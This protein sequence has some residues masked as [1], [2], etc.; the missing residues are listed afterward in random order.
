MTE[1]ARGFDWWGAVRVERAR[2][3]CLA[4]AL[5]VLAALALRTAGVTMGADSRRGLPVGL[6]LALLRRLRPAEA[7]LRRLVVV[8]AHAMLPPAVPASAPA[9]RTPLTAAQRDARRRRAVARERERA[10]Q[11]C[12]G[13]LAPPPP[14]PF[15]LVDPEAPL[16]DGAGYV[17]VRP[18]PRGLRISVLGMP[19]PAPRPVPPAPPMPVEALLGRIASL[20]AAVADLGGQ[21]E[22]LRRWEARDLARRQRADRA[23][24]GCRPRGS[25]LRR[26]RPPGHRARGGGSAHDALRAAHA[27]AVTI[28][29]PRLDSS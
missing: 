20:S 6:R 2:I 10:W 22:R 8:A 15:R 25:A 12:R 26:G 29:P 16:D 3:A 27:L 19:V 24:T 5:R 21:A 17:A 13:R 28:P 14:P 7:A 1:D 18:V 11:R 9:R 23:R 4:S